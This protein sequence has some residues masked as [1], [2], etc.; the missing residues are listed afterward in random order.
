MGL[1]F[2]E[3]LQSLDDL[4]CFITTHDPQIR[5]FLEQTFGNSARQKWE[6]IRTG[7]NKLYETY[8]GVNFYV[9]LI[10][11]N[12]KMLM[13]MQPMGPAHIYQECHVLVPLC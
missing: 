11:S 5:V 1:F 6:L 2:L 13:I 7:Y 8:Q 4:V 3:R 12:T 9:S 10:L